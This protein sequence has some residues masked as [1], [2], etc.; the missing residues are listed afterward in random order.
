MFV[1]IFVVIVLVGDYMDVEVVC[2]FLRECDVV[3]FDYE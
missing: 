1:G 3:M 2:V